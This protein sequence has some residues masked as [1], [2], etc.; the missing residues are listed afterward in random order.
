L[1]VQVDVPDA[2]FWRLAGAAE[3]A[4]LRVD[5]WLV[6]LATTFEG[7]DDDEATGVAVRWRRGLCDADVARELGWT[8][9]RA[10]T[11]RRE[12]GLPA[13]KRRRVR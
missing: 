4:G 6:N 11:V 2:L 5:Q 1:K 3:D 12:L 7:R 13:N 9:L 10:A 8:N